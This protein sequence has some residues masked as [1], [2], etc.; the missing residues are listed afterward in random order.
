MLPKYKAILSHRV[1][2]SRHR[3]HAAE[4]GDRQARQCADRDDVLALIGPD[5]TE[6][7]H[8]RRILIDLLVRN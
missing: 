4:H 5:L 6:H 7:L 2:Y 1:N 8:Q 3:K